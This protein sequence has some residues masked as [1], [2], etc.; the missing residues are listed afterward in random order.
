M[1][2]AIATIG[3]SAVLA[4]FLA[5]GVVTASAADHEVQMLNRGAEGL[6]VFE[7]ALVRVQPGDTVN[8]ISVD[9]GHNVESIA[10]M[11]P[12]DI[13][14]FR[15]PISKDFSITFDKPGLYGYKC[16]PHFAMGM[17]GLVVVGDA[18][19][20]VVPAAGVRLPRKAEQRF[21]AIFANL[22]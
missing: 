21:D 10:G 15:G 12:E 5:A 13:E 2:N 22:Q 6:M 1:R 19:V 8:F 4:A 7:P 11:I 16:T 3:I 9:K 14:P 20:D 18:P 17:V